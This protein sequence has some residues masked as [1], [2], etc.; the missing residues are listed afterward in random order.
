MTEWASGRCSFTYAQA[1]WRSRWY[2]LILHNCD[3]MARAPRKWRRIS[4]LV[5]RLAHCKHHELQHIVPESISQIR[6]NTRCLE[7]ELPEM[8]EQVIAY[9][10]EQGK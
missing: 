3:Q 7:L 6:N 8:L 2:D 1:P 5:G 9:E 4:H 10:R